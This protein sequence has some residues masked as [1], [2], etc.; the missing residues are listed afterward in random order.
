MRSLLLVL[1][2]TLAAWSQAPEKVRIGSKAFPES[3]VLGEACV[4]LARS[5]GAEVEY[6]KSLG[7]TEIIYQALKQGSIDIYPEYTGT[8]RQVFLKQLPDATD[9]DA[10]EVLARDRLGMSYSL[11]FTDSYALAVPARVQGPQTLSELNDYPDLR[12]V[13]NQEFVGRQDGWLGLAETYGLKPKNFSEMQHELCYTAIASN[14]ADVINVYTTDAQIEKLGLRLLRDDKNY[15]SRY[16][17]VWLYRADLPERCPKAWAAMQRLV[18]RVSEEK[19]R[20]ANAKMIIDK[21]DANQAAEFL[22]EQ[23]LPAREGGVGNSTA[24]PVAKK[25]SGWKPEVLWKQTIQH[26]KLVTASLTLAVLVGIPLGVLASRS[27]TTARVTLSL[28]GLLQTIPSLALLAFMVPIT[29]VGWKPALVALFVYSILPIVRNT[30]TG[31][32]TLPGNLSEAAHALGLPVSAQL[33]RIRLP[34][35][36]PSILAGIKTSS[37]INV[38]TATLAALVGAG[39]LGESI[40]Q[41]ISLLDHQMIFQGAIPAALLALLAQ[42]FWDVVERW[43]VPRGLRI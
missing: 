22:L 30:Y 15:F 6:R 17:C 35:A 20:Q 2:L 39:G 36:S 3:W 40:L 28:V 9:A 25:R 12:Y 32:T 41:G 43:I 34:M 16:D 14:Q 11:G 5:S 33:W 4:Q 18:G 42:A 1:I 24:P 7:A 29:G 31:L 27:P 26:L 21:L 19:M 8:I 10:L 37:V 38:G 13:M 23:C